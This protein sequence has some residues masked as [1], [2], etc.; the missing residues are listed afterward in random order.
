MRNHLRIANCKFHSYINEE[1]RSN[2]RTFSRNV[3]FSKYIRSAMHNKHFHIGKCAEIRSKSMLIILKLLHVLLSFYLSSSFPA[4]TS[5]YLSFF[6][7][8]F[9]FYYF[10][11]TSSYSSNVLPVIWPYF[12]PSSYQ[13]SISL[14][15]SSLLRK[16][17]HITLCFIFQTG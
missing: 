3:R 5:H 13:H 16:R 4:F 7:S 10:V 12:S 11:E 8:I 2:G 15:V 17:N 9:S 1:K 6:H 14:I